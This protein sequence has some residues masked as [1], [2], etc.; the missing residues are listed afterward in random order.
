MKVVCVYCGL[1]FGVWLVYVDVVCVFG[2][3][4]VDVGFMFV[5][6]GGCVGLMGVIVDEV[7]V[8]GGC[9]VG[10]IFELFVDKEVGYMGLLELYV[11]FDM[12]YCKKM[13]VDFFDVFVVMFGGV[14]MFEEF[15][16]VYMWV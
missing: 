8:V 9:V 13:M 11:V 7:M 14:G 10:V 1:L 5:Y 2:C 16:E 4:F 3:V 12:Y 15:F 6:G